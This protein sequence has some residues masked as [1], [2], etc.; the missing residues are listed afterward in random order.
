MPA[1]FGRPRLAEPDEAVVTSAPGPGGGPGALA[2][3]ASM[4][5]IPVIVIEDG[6]AARPLADALAAGGLRCAEITLRTPAALDAITCF[7]GNGSLLVGA[8]TVLDP[9]QVSA[10]VDA[11]ARFVVSPGF[12]AEVVRC[13]QRLGVPVLP[14]TATPSEIQ[15]AWR[16]GLTAVKFFPAETLGGIAA[17]SA[18]AAPFPGMTFVPTGGITAANVSA[19]LRHRA[20]LAVGGSWMAPRSLVAAGDWQRIG[21]LAGEAAGLA[22]EFPAAADMA[23]DGRAPGPSAA[24]AHGGK[25]P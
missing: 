1:W 9:E 25:R 22:A 16:A 4:R 3:L 14:G 8:G 6:A 20:V 19:Y 23:A 2:S 13:C 18:I 11:G 5:V 21:Q 15:Q 17:L 24:N 10:A 7:A 12:D